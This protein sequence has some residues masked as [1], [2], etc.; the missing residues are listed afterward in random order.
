MTCIPR[1]VTA[2]AET[3]ITLR[4]LRKASLRGREDQRQAV[5]LLVKSDQDGEFVSASL[6]AGRWALAWPGYESQPSFDATASE[7]LRVKL[8]DI[9]GRCTVFGADCRLV[10]TST[11]R[12]AEVA[13]GE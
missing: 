5:T 7:K 6:A 12:H 8:E 2:A 3:K 10:S 13:P 1:L 11:Q 9:A 4:P